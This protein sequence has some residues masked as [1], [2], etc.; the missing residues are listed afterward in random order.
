MKRVYKRLDMQA[1]DIN[2]YFCKQL[3][4]SCQDS[5]TNLMSTDKLVIELRAG[6]ISPQHEAIIK[7]T[8]LTDS[9]KQ[10]DFLDFLTYLPLFILIHQSVVSNPFDNGRGK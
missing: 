6:G 4:E 2:T 8:L 10:L 9:T 1:M 7:K 5:D 3:W